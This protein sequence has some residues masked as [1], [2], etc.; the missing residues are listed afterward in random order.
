MDIKRLEGTALNETILNSQPLEVSK[1][2]ENLA[3]AIKTTVSQALL[4][5]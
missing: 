2:S 3:I 4:G 1:E 5:A